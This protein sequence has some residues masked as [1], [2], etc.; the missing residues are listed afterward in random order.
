MRMRF[1]FLLFMRK[2]SCLLWKAQ[3]PETPLCVQPLEEEKD[4]VMAV[5]IMQH[6]SARVAP[7]KETYDLL[8]NKPVSYN[9]Q[10]RYFIYFEWIYFDWVSIWNLPHKLLLSV[11]FPF[12]CVLARVFCH[13][14]MCCLQYCC[15]FL[16]VFWVS[17]LPM[18]VLTAVVHHSAPQCI[19]TAILHLR[20]LGWVVMLHAW[21]CGRFLRGCLSDHSHP[22][23][24]GG[25]SLLQV[26]SSL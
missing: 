13:L 17:H 22:V 26:G 6:L 1:F 18:H 9:T 11:K 23:E 12:L 10:S 4:F 14:P 20:L 25:G 21:G 7:Y 2:N 8:I 24:E 15:G 5:F 16:W 3:Q 19:V